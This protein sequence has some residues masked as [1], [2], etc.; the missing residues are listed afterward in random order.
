VPIFSPMFL[1]LFLPCR[2]GRLKYSRYQHHINQAI[3]NLLTLLHIAPKGVKDVHEMLVK[4]ADSLIRGGETGT[5]SPMHLLVFK[6]P[7]A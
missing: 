5:F 1:R 3:V 6:K 7:E 2:Y 4:V